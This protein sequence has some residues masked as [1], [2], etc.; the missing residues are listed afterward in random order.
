VKGQYRGELAE[1]VARCS[2]QNGVH[3][4]A[5]GHGDPATE[6]PVRLQGLGEAKTG[7]IADVR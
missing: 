6:P 2:G 4:P 7:E 3:D 1:I 5:L